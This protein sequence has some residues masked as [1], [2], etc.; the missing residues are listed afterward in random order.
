MTV[1]LNVADCYDFNTG[2]WSVETEYPGDLWEHACVS[3]NV[4]VCR[5]DPLVRPPS[6]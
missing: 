2:Q 3:L 5:D 1:R 6:P 4:P